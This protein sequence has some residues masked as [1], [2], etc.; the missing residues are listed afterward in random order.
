MSALVQANPG[1]TQ[2]KQVEGKPAEEREEKKV[3]EEKDGGEEN[4]PT[5]EDLKKE[6]DRLLTAIENIPKNVGEG[7]E[8][9]P[10]DI[11]ALNKKLEEISSSM[12]QLA[13]TKKFSESLN[14]LGPLIDN[15]EKSVDPKVFE[16]IITDTAVGTANIAVQTGL[17]TLSTIPVFGTGFT[18]FMGLG[19][20]VIKLAN[21]VQRG[22]E[23]GTIMINKAVDKTTGNTGKIINK[24]SSDPP[25]IT[26]QT[27]KETKVS[28]QAGGA[29]TRR[30]LKRVIRDREL[31]QTR[32]NK[33]IRE[34]MNPKHAITQNKKYIHRK[35]KR[36][37]RR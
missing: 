36:R 9:I 19:Q 22:L 31:I 26:G 12:V 10:Q 15:L 3:E 20:T 28:G 24:N 25:K 11:L 27:T 21:G 14:A 23:A 37:R 5:L 33:M 16:N 13:D 17:K 6:V 7:F 29:K 35:S 34:F 32:T 1:K 2:V 8:A 30:H 4:E 18:A